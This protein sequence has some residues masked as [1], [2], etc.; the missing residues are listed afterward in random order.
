MHALRRKVAQN[1]YQLGRA[2]FDTLRLRLLKVAA[3]VSQSTRRILI[4]LP[5]A[6]VFRQLF[7]QLAA[8]LNAPPTP[9]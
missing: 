5:R 8:R 6:F 3:M 7:W 1:S 9:A 2:Q 4:R